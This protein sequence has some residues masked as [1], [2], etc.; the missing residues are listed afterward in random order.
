MNADLS[1]GPEERIK[2]VENWRSRVKKLTPRHRVIVAVI[3]QKLHAVRCPGTAQ[4]PRGDRRQQKL[5]DVPA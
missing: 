2:R 5:S 3:P 1:E 4:L